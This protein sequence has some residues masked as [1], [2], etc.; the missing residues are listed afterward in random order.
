MTAV[1]GSKVKVHYTGT[2]NHGEVFDSSLEGCPLEFEV[3][4]GQVIPGF[5][6]AVIGMS[7]GDSKQVRIPEE[8]AYGPYNPEMMFE[9]DPSQ[10]EEG[11]APEAGQQF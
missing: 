4:A 10:F 8:E 7:V 1:H 9:T 5:E 3:G 6:K 11:L 2:Y